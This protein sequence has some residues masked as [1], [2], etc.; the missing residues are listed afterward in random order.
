MF[1]S[2]ATLFL[3]ATAKSATILYT[4]FETPASAPDKKLYLHTYRMYPPLS[5]AFE[6]LTGQDYV[7]PTIGTFTSN[8]K[9]SK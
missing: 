8:H 1:W 4:V 5:L 2:K 7:C 9:R 3:F 6:L